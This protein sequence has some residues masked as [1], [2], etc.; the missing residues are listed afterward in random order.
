LAI[1]LFYEKPGCGTNARQKRMLEAA[2]HAVIAVSLLEERWTAGRLLSF[3]GDTPVAAWFNPAAPRV[4]SGEVDPQ[5]IDAASALE[6]LV[7]DHLLIRRPLVEV[8]AQRCAGFD[9]EPVTSLLAGLQ[10]A[11]VVE[12]C[13]RPQASTPCPDPRDLEKPS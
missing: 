9:R 4:K 6:V 10:G 2:G 1:V 12:G 13:S 3:F 11:E 7:E 5:Q 8:G